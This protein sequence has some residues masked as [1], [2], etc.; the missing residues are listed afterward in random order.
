M[1]RIFVNTTES[2]ANV[3]NVTEYVPDYVPN[4]IPRPSPGT[5][6]GHE[7][8]CLPLRTDID[9]MSQRS[10]PLSTHADAR[11]VRP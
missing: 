3:A 4:F 1:T 5:S 9:P 10:G 8:L 6:A 2:V 7:A 11:S